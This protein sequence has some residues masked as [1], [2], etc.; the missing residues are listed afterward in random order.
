MLL[1][2][3]WLRGIQSNNS[4]RAARAANLVEYY[5]DAN[6]DLEYAHTD[7]DVAVPVKIGEL[8]PLTGPW[9]SLGEA[10]HRSGSLA[11][12]HLKEAGYEIERVV[13]DTQMSATAAVSA[14]GQ[15]V[16]VEGVHALVGA[17][18]SGAT[19]PVAE[20]VSI[21]GQVPQISYGSTSPSITALPADQG[22]DFLFRT[23][24]SDALQGIVLAKMIREE[25]LKKVSVL[26]VDNA[27]GQG[28]NDVFS[29]TFESLGGTVVASVPHDEGASATYT[30]ELQLATEGEPEALVAMSYPSHAKVYLKQAIDG[31][32]IDNFRF[33]DGTKSQEII[34]AVGAEA[35]EGMCGTA[36]ATAE[37]ES[38]TIFNTEY[39]AEYGE[40]PSLPFMTN[41]Y[42][43]VIVAALAAYEAQIADG[44]LTPVAV[45]DRLR[46]VAGSPGEKVTPGAEGLEQAL[47][48]LGGGK[49][50][51]Y[52]GAS[53]DVDFDA[54]GEVVTP[55]EIWCYKDGEIVSER[56]EMPFFFV[57]LP[58]TLRNY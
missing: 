16:D 52:V 45:R 57:Y 12:K 22:Q 7:P 48:S 38:L 50:I 1:A 55:I 21:P 3:I 19:I 39:E 27:Y 14:A 29:N 18:S 8:Y 33:V 4:P 11:A 58:L 40:A 6:N 36:P 44:E 26:Y 28:L 17:A 24:P 13:T 23:C 5:D 15:L 42:D 46:S 35:V 37:T 56:L 32:F 30:T 51:D 31:G 25:G 54:N 20:S 9:P 53:G 41:A 10:L 34:D 43:A 49:D 47:E 2:G